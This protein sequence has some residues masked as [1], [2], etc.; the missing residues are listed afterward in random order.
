MRPRT[1]TLP[2]FTLGAALLFGI[3]A[4]AGDLPKEGTYSGT[5]SSFGTVKA[6]TIGKERVLLAFDENGLSVG[7]GLID[8]VTWHCWGLGDTTNGMAEWHGYCVMTDPAGDQIAAN[9]ASD[10]KYAADA[11]SLR[12][13]ARR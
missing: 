13:Q 8:H 2:A 12:G 10:G 7:Q 4:S 3:A 5:Y 1:Y 9:V 6:T 11:K